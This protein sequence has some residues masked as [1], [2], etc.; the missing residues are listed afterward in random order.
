MTRR[1]LQ[2]LVSSVAWKVLTLACLTVFA[3]AAW[4]QATT[5]LNGTVTDPSGSA[6]RGA[7]VTIVNASTGFKRSVT[8]SADGTY[9]FPEILP[10][11][12]TVTVENSGFSKFEEKGVELRVELPRTVNVQMKVG[13]AQ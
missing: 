13:T 3:V 8:T 2:S 12:Y 9:V 4:G 5:T 7:Q 6:I 1:S 10:G 11:T